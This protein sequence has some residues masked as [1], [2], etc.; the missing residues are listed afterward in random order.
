MIQ[1]VNYFEVYDN[2]SED[3]RGNDVR[4]I[5]RFHDRYHAEQYAVGR[6]NYG[7][8]AQI[9]EVKFSIASYASEVE[10]AQLEDKKEAALAKLTYDERK[11]LGLE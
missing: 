2:F 11:L 7:H 6:G 9:R 5:A 1:K 4:V 8:D 10:K 3:G